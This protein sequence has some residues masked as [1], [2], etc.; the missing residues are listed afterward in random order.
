L[1]VPVAHEAQPDRYPCQRFF[2][3]N[4]QV[5]LNSGMPEYGVEDSQVSMTMLRATSMLSKPRLW[6]RG[7]GA[8]PNLEI[9]E[10]NCKGEM[11]CS[12]GWAPLAA[13]AGGADPFAQ[14]F[15]LAE[16]YEG[17]LWAAQSR[18]PNFSDT[19]AAV[20]SLLQLDNPAI[21]LSALYIDADGD[22]V[23]RLLNTTASSQLC[24]VSV[25]SAIFS[26][27]TVSNL[28][29]DEREALTA[30]LSAPAKPESAGG[31]P[32]SGN[33]W[34]SVEMEFG[35]AQL[36]TLRLALKRREAA[37]RAEAA[38]TAPA[39]AAASKATTKSKSAKS[40]AKAKLASRKKQP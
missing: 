10:A 33:S 38:I 1:P 34:Q 14:A 25:P 31:S 27:V 7:G 18:N 32:V 3:A 30:V 39:P 8:G 13:V 17:P 20:C 37:K 15:R 5:F 35:R 36:V 9:P 21:R 24:R 29:G 19:G 4:G 40:S 16:L 22:M 23:L 2:L 11:T 26:T 6:T 28:G 12:Y